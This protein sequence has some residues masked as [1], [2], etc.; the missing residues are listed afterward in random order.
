MTLTLA[1]ALT[2]GSHSRGPRSVKKVDQLFDTLEKG[3]FLLFRSF[4]DDKCAT[5][6]TVVR[7]LVAEAEKVS[8]KLSAGL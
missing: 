2:L 7:S 6:K 8:G 3:Q 4:H 1:L 5:V